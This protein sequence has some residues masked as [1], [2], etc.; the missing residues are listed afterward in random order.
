MICKPIL[1]ITCFLHNKYLTNRPHSNRNLKNIENIIRKFQRSLLFGNV[2]IIPCLFLFC[3]RK[4]PLDNVRNSVGSLVPG[5]LHTRSACCNP[6]R[7]L[8]TTFNNAN[9][10]LEW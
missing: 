7:L 4:V 10:L 5:G 3:S 1:K 8:V 9:N 6:I 2:L